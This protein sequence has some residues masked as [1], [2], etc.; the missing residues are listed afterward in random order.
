[1]SQVSLRSAW[2]NRLLEAGLAIGLGLLLLGLSAWQSMARMGD[3]S[4]DWTGL[5]ASLGLKLDGTPLGDA[6]AAFIF[7]QLLLHAGFGL[8]C[9]LLALITARAFP[10]LRA[11]RRWLIAAWVAVA[12]LWV[13]VGN[14][15]MFPWSGSGF[16]ADFFVRPLAGGVRLFDLFTLILLAAVGFIALRNVATLPRVRRVLPRVAAYSALALIAWGAIGW[17]RASGEPARVA[18]GNT[19]PNIILIGVDSLR[20]D[21]VGQVRG[22]GVT[23]NID[24]FLRDG[25]HTFNDAVT[26][27]ARTFASWTAI[28]SG[29]NPR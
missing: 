11:R 1:M 14:A 17:M 18:Q 20:R 7:F 26:P 6:A 23:P 21:A 8:V 15:T 24:V 19:A 16:H 2:R 10:P 3:V 12:A 9:W 29:R 25:A 13:L 22:L 27:L 5:I 28:L 4:A